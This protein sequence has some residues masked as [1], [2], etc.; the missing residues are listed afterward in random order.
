M[1]DIG[2][3]ELII[4]FVVALLVVGPKNLPELGSTIGK[5]LRGLKRSVFE[6]K[7][8]IQRELSDVPKPQEPQP[9]I[10]KDK[11]EHTDD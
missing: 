4:I 9:D 6:A 8:E 10:N 7:T 5:G 2:L 11:K 3:Q 1:F